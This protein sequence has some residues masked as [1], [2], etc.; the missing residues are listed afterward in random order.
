MI[1]TDVYTFLDTLLKS[2][3]NRTRGS[4][5]HYTID[6]DVFVHPPLN[7]TEKVSDHF[8]NIIP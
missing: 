1:V 2:V 6:Y 3:D 7:D 8:N 5:A 4:C